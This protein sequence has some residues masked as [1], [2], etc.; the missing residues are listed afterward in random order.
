MNEYTNATAITILAGLVATGLW[1]WK[2]WYASIVKP[3][4]LAKIEREDGLAESQK[5]FIAKVSG[6]VA[7]TEK[8]FERMVVSQ[9]QSNERIE[10]LIEQQDMIKEGQD[11]LTAAVT[12][13]ITNP[14]MQ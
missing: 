6:S 9:E 14:E 12:E 5:E 7:A 11:A 8:L 4:A 10:Y 2:D 13:A 3:A 1:W